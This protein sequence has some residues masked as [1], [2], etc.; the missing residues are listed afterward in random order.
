MNLRGLFLIVYGLITVGLFINFRASFLIYTSF[1]IN[2]IVLFLVV[3]YHL[4]YEKDN[5]PFISAFIVFTF[6]FFLVAPIIQIN[7]FYELEFPRFINYFP[8][9]EK[10]VVY[11]NILIFLFNFCFIFSYILFKNKRIKDNAIKDKITYKYSA[12]NILCVLVCSFLIFF[13]SY[14]FILWNLETPS[15]LEYKESVIK[16]LGWKKV[17]F[18]VPFG[19]VIL[20]FQYLKNRKK[21]LSI[22]FIIVLISL[23]CFIFL[24]FWFKNPFT[25]KR[26]ALGPIYLCLVF[27]LYPK[28]FS[29]NVKNISILFFIM[30]VLFPLSSI[31][32]N[33]DAT[34][35]QILQNPEIL[36]NEAKYGG[37]TKTFN[38][39]H[40]DAFANV[41]A[42]IAYVSN[43]GISYGFQL[44]S[45]FLFFIPRSIWV[46]KPISTGQLIGEDLIRN[47]G[48]NFSN[49]SN[50]LVSEGY[51]N[52]G[53][54]GVLLFAIFFAFAI[55][56]FLKWFQSDSMIKKILAFYLAIHLLFLLRGDFTNGF[57]YYIGALF[58]VM[59]IPSMIN[60]FIT[61]LF[62]LNRKP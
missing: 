23:L 60:I 58:G 30:I 42:T 62:K 24:L 56:K 54:V 13:F 47:Y 41:N 32:T 39:L 17:L 61:E 53:V 31:L 57:S 3:I 33:T 28:I 49:L 25:E 8:F 16:I 22:N 11:S 6:L 37:L 44:L 40:Y 36:L 52:F 14:D 55:V 18:M 4:Y 59:V 1:V 46:D 26:N 50:P 27:L 45:A 15:W 19:G 21:K 43:N 12:L 38:T 9:N 35:W 10:L 7:T 34:F 51:I 2:A 29:N 48:F 5:S 20:C